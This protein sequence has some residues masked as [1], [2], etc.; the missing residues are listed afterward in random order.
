MATTIN[1]RKILDRK[2]WEFCT[3]APAATAAGVFVSSSRLFRQ[4]QYMLVNATTAWEYLP[5]EDAWAE[6]PNPSLGG[7]FAAGACGVCTPMGPTGTATAGTTTTLTTNLNI[8]RDLRGFKIRIVS[9]ACAGDERTIASNW[10]GS[11]AVITVTNPF[12]STINNTSVYQLITTRW[13][14]FNAHT[15]APVANQFKYYDYAL[16]TWTAPANLPAVGAAWGTDGRM[17]ATPSIVDA[18]NVIFVSGTATSGTSNTLYNS[19]KTWTANQFANAYQVR[20][21]SGTGIGQ[22]RY[23]ASNT[24][25]AI[26]VT[27]AFSPIPD[28]TS[29]YVVEGSDDNLFLMGNNAVTLYKYS[30]SNGTWTTLSPGVA[31]AGAS[32]AGASGHWVWGSNDSVWANESILLNGKR[33]YSFRGN[34]ATLDTYDIPAN[35][36]NNAV[37]YSPGLATFAAGSKYSII[38]GRHIWIQKDATNRFYR[39]DPVKYEMDPGA[40][41]LYPQGAAVAGDTCFDV[42]YTDGATT[43]TWLYMI[44]NTSQVMLRMMLI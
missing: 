37:S 36:W 4:M 26:T 21:V 1:L 11:N 23:I 41:F 20:I 40:Q 5:E 19:S 42:S 14:V 43:I 17:I 33:I 13:W 18:T 34:A 27:S 44:L 22:I 24:T 15:A 35:T 7:T 38:N 25:S 12:S 32:V 8:L 29:V 9:G 6:L 28:S 3:P 30:I 16:N 2:Q 10:V 39:F 31:R